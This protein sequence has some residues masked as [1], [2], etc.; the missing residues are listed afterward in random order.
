MRVLFF[1]DAHGDEPALRL[2]SRISD[3][4]DAVIIGGDLTGKGSPDYPSRMLET[5]GRAGRPTYYVPGNADSLSLTLPDEVTSLHGSRSQLGRYA[6]GGLGGSNVT[7]FNTALEFPDPEAEK[8]LRKLGHVDVLV[9]HCPPRGC[10][11]DKTGSGHIGSTPV[12]AYVDEH[13]PALVLSGHVHESHAVDNLAGTTVVNPG[14]LK[15][16]RYAVI[17]LN[18]IISV[19]LKAE[20]L[21]G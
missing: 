3:G 7:P 6:I 2:A 17:D 10:K 15:D 4:F 11:C 20:S 5:I 9:S 21:K 14:P 18:G 1:T 19:E 8:I 12:R 16:G 13:H